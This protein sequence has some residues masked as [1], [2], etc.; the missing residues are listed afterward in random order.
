MTLSPAYGSV[1]RA[2]DPRVVCVY[3][4][5]AQVL[6]PPPK[7]TVSQWAERERMLS[8]ESSATTGRYRTAIA[9]YQRAMQDAVN[10][11]GVQVITLFTSAQIG[12]SLCL[13]NMFGY[14]VAEDP[15]P[16]IYMWPTLDVAKSWS[17]ETLD[18]MLRD[19]PVL[20]KRVVSGSRKG[21]NGMLFKGFPGGFLAVIGANAASGLRRRRA[22]IVFCEEIDAYPQSAGDEGDPRQLVWKRSTTFWNKLRIEAST[23]TIKGASPIEASYEA[24][25]QQMFHVPCPHC[26]EKQVLKWKRLVYPKDAKPTIDN[27]HYACEGCGVALTEFDKPLMLRD[28]EWRAKFPERVQHQ[29]FWINELYSPFVKWWEMATAWLEAI[30]HRENPELLK[31]FVNTALAETWEEKDVVIDKDD[32]RSR[33]VDYSAPAQMLDFVTVLTAG[34][35]VQEDRLEIK[36]KGWGKGEESCV[37]DWH[38][39]DGDTAKQETWDQLDEYLQRKFLHPRGVR[40]DIAS[41]F[42]DSGYRAVEVY[43]FTKTRAHRRVFASKGVAGFQ[44]PAVGKWTRNNQERVKLYP[45]GVDVIKSTIYARLNISEPGAGC[46]HFHRGSCDDEY[47]VGLTCEKLRRKYK[48]G[49]PIRYWELP[50]GARNE[51]LDCEVYAFAAF[52]SLAQNIAK[53]LEFLREGLIAQAKRLAEERRSKIDPRQMALLDLD[54]AGELAAADPI[55]EEAAAEPETPVEP[56][57]QASTIAQVAVALNEV[58]Q[59]PVPA[60]EVPESPKSSEPRPPIIRVKK[61]NWF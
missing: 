19:T 31:T 34:V 9:P 37:V 42:I 22:R 4:E 33:A 53:M 2:L 10:I 15:G 50:A 8:S 17:V 60:V 51:P 36:V 25:N 21:G 30:A 20:A 49:F 5:A 13:E 26:G 38:R 47:F 48:N 14:F 29:G 43:K 12:K 27:T 35:D 55:G 44:R 59:P 1:N 23:C 11:P 46:M 40:L 16:I 45:I 57:K 56:E 61:G 54:Q 58:L 32:L 6:K 18:P 39:I 28:G 52:H 24:S 3:Q 41:T 7:T